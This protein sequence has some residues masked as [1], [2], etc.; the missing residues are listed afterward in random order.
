M[1]RD[2]AC[3]CNSHNGTV[4]STWTLKNSASVRHSRV[5]IK[6]RGHIAFLGDLWIRETTTK[7]RFYGIIT[8]TR[9]SFLA[10]K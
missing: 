2:V 5:A 10:V 8:S 1:C 9:P 7:V 4:F 3:K 6:Q